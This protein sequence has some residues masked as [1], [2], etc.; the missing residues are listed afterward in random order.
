MSRFE[1]ERLVLRAP[2]T[3]DV[4]EIALALN[5]FEITK[6][7]A[8]VPHPYTETDA[9]AYVARA[10]EDRAKGTTFRFVMRRKSDGALI[11][12][13]GLH[14]KDGGYDIGYW[15]ARA[16]WRQ[17]YASEA[18]AGLVDFAFN[19][20]GAERLMAGWYHDNGVSGLILAKLGFKALFVEK[21][22]S[23][24]RGYDVLCNRCMLTR[25]EFGQKTHSEAWAAPLA[26]VP[27]A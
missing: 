14:R 17:G 4:H 15:I 12:A 6:N 19:E 1:T 9:Y 10:T 13:C 5:D 18:A 21:Q 27:A 11:G 24:A 8:M 7:L 16:H 3:R 23:A 22:H 2:Q 26:V 25:E 20:L